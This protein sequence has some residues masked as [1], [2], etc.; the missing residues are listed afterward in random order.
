MNLVEIAKK[1]KQVRILI[2]EAV[3]SIDNSDL[4]KLKKSA[5]LT[6]YGLEILDTIHIIEIIREMK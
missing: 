4:Q 1:V 5:Q 3:Q 6:P 2:N